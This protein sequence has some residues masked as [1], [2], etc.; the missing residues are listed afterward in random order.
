MMPN[1]TEYERYLNFRIHDALHV[2]YRIVTCAE[3]T[4]KHKSDQGLHGYT[5]VAIGESNYVVV[6]TPDLLRA[7]PIIRVQLSKRDSNASDTVVFECIQSEIYRPNE[8]DKHYFV[9]G[10]RTWT[11]HQTPEKVVKYVNLL[12]RMIQRIGTIVADFSED[13]V[14]SCRIIGSDDVFDE[15]VDNNESN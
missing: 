2:M 12:Q 8:V 10:W 5:S 6:I 11:T 3:R 4:F 9:W 14:K 13:T 15:G 1:L 7:S